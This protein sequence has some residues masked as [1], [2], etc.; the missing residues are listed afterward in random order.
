MPQENGE[1]VKSNCHSPEINSFGICFLPDVLTRYKIKFSTRSTT[2]EVISLCKLSRICLVDA[3][4][5]ALILLLFKLLLSLCICCG[6]RSNGAC[7]GDRFGWHKFNKDSRNAFSDC[8]SHNA[9][10]TAAS[11][12]LFNMNYKYYNLLRA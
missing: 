5:A 7:V 2:Q 8:S 11:L 4:S 3:A 10:G 1:I 9:G 12:Y 6:N